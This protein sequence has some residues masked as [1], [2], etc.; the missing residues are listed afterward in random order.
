MALRKVLKKMCEEKSYIHG[1]SFAKNFGQHAAFM[2]G[3]R[4]ADGDVCVCL[5]DD[6]Q[7]PA[8]EVGKLLEKIEEGFDAVYA[9]YEH[10]QPRDLEILEAE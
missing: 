1:I 5:D 6:G 8:C 3:F 2:A 9:K 4:A 10:K 7:T